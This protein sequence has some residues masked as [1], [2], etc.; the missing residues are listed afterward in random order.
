MVIIYIIVVVIVIAVMM[1]MPVNIQKNAP[2]KYTDIYLCQYIIRRNAKIV[3]INDALF[4][5]FTKGAD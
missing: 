3:N 4:I 1:S 5:S 2:L